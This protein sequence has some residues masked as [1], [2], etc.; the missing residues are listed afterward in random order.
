ML[1][2]KP[3][4]IAVKPL[5][6]PDTIETASGIVLHVPDTAKGRADQGIV[7][8]IGEGCKLVSVLDHVLF[9]GYSGTLV[10][11][12][13]EGQLIF[14]PEKFVTCIV[15]DNPLM[16]SGLFVK[17]LPF[18]NLDE[19]PT[20]S[21]ATF[22][23]IVELVTRQYQ[24][25]TKIKPSLRDAATGTIN[26]SKMKNAALENFLEDEEDEYDPREHDSLG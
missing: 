17:N 12:E 16:I 4:Y 15:H 13:G 20:Y 1:T 25:Y 18:T 21:K 6:D 9:S 8:Y 24:E 10:D 3:K 2:P 14:M 19:V 23:S 22:E 5:Y 11:I 7:K 26:H